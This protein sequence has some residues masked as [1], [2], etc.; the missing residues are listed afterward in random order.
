MFFPPPPQQLPHSN[1]V[2]NGDQLH[3]LPTVNIA[4]GLASGGRY[5]ST[6]VI[7]G[8]DRLPVERIATLLETGGPFEDGLATPHEEPASL[9]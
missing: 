7:R 5:A 8:A 1:A 6:P 3:L 9:M 2:W 4:V